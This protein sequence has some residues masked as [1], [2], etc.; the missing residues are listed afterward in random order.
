MLHFIQVTRP[1]VS[2]SS[3]NR[4][5]GSDAEVWGETRKED[6]VDE[7]DAII[8]RGD[9]RPK[10]VWKLILLPAF[11]NFSYEMSSRQP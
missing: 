7:I 11:L 10:H 2:P 4:R 8:A 5:D 9:L 1:S 3:Q 6:E